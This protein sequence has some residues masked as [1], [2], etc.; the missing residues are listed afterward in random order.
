MSNLRVLALH[1]DIDFSLGE[2]RLRAELDPVIRSGPDARTILDLTDVPFAD[3][4]FL[5]VLIRCSAALGEKQPRGRICIV[6][7]RGT[8]VFRLFEITNLN[9]TFPV[10]EELSSAR[11]YISSPKTHW[12]A[13]PRSQM[14][15]AFG[16]KP[17]FGSLAPSS[18]N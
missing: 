11:T 8:L 6:A 18:A 16:S 3:A 4:A 1:G 15:V 10:F 12:G 2:R 14:I 9:R 17:D 13:F 7:H 5:G